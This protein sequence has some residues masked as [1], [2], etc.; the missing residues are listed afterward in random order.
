MIFA[1][2]VEAFLD[3]LRTR[4][5][6]AARPVQVEGVH[7]SCER[8]GNISGP[9]TIFRHKNSL[10]VLFKVVQSVLHD[11]VREIAPPEKIECSPVIRLIPHGNPDDSGNFRVTVEV[12]IERS[13]VR[14]ETG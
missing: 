1:S 13:T 7:H 12:L 10:E 4:A 11:V 9:E 3:F 5:M 2:A 14:G 6:G 8:V